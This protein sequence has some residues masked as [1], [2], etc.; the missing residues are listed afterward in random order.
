MDR[1][2]IR[3]DRAP[4][5]I[6]PYSQAVAAGDLVFLSGQIGLDPATATL[7]S[8]GTA[9]EADQVLK[10]LQ[11]VLAA[12]GLDFE[13]VVRTTIYLVDLADFAAVNDV[14]QR[15]VR[16]PYPA[17]ATVG[18]AALPRGARVE[19]DAIAVRGR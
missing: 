8:G 1:S 19:I 9:A 12:A 2:A 4:Q 7:V 17:R 18:A 6:G 3:T 16:E 15:Y 5:A 13:A 11:A 10:N 14:Y